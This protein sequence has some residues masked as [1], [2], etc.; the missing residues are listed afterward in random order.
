MNN[1]LERFVKKVSYVLA[2]I[3]CRIFFLDVWNET[4]LK[5]LNKQYMDRYSSRVISE[6]ETITYRYT[7]LL[8]ILFQIQLME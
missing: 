3:T 4:S 1:E 6:K 2:L 7:I 8:G 5:P